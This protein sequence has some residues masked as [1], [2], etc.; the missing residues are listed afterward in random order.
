MANRRKGTAGKLS[1]AIV[2]VIVL[3]SAILY[4]Y[5]LWKDPKKENIE[6]ECEF[7]FIDV[8][9]GDSTLI[10]TEDSV[11][12]IDAGPGKNADSTLEYVRN[13]TDSID[14]FILTHP[15]ED[16]IGGADDILDTVPVKNVILSDAS[17][18]TVAFTKLLDSIESS[19]ANV[20]EA[21]AGDKYTAGDI[22]FTILSPL[23]AFTNYNDYSIVTRIEYG[24]TAVMVTGDVE[25]HSEG[26]ICEKYLPTEL[27]ADIYRVAH[28]GSSTSNSD[29]FMRLVDPEY[30]I[31]SCGEGNSYGHPHVETVDKLEKMNLE[32]YRTDRDGHLVFV[33]DGENVGMK[34]EDKSN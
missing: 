30:A 16:H 23:S 8:G 22:E 7:H 12:L 9:Q 4:V 21:K 5:D 11:I 28:H 13:H 10:L 3:V 32:Y 25:N 29:E 34:T 18:D 33:S 26:L 19:N 14:Y 15:H 31:I 20:I 6:G 24:E 17:T 27:R 2:S 1:A